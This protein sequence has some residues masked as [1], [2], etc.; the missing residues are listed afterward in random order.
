M[1]RAF[2]ESV[3]EGA[4]LA[5]SKGRGLSVNDDEESEIAADGEAGASS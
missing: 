1:N 5:W 3:V 2:T 4:A